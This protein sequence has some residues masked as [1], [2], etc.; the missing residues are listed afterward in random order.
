MEVVFH[1]V[2]DYHGGAERT[3][4]RF[5]VVV[6]RKALDRSAQRRF[7]ANPDDAPVTC[8]SVWSRSNTAT[9]GGTWDGTLIRRTHL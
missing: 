4:A 9:S 5:D 7:G 2:A 8:S 1:P 3:Q 6:E